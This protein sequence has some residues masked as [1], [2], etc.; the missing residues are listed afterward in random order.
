M[1]SVQ[2]L[3]LSCNNLPPSGQNK[4]IIKAN[5]NFWSISKRNSVPGVLFMMVYNKVPAIYYWIIRPYCFKGVQ[6][7]EIVK[8]LSRS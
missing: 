3:I 4:F 2:N 6:E 7:L 1:Y 8:S 5:Y